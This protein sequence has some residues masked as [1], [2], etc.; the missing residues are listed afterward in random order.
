M[1]PGRGG[2]GGQELA[3]GH[4]RWPSCARGPHSQPAAEQTEAQRGTRAASRGAGPVRLNPTLLRAQS[5]ARWEQLDSLVA[6]GGALWQTP[7][8]PAAAVPSPTP[9][10]SRE[11]SR[12]QAQAQVEAGLGLLQHSSKTQSLGSAGQPLSGPLLSPHA[13]WGQARASAASLPGRPGAPRVTRGPACSQL[14]CCP[15]VWGGQASGSRAWPALVSG[16]PG[17]GQGLAVRLETPRPS[18]FL[19]PGL[20]GP[21]LGCGPG[22]C[23]L[24]S[25]LPCTPAPQ[26]SSHKEGVRRGPPEPPARPWCRGRWRPPQRQP[27]GRWAGRRPPGFGGPRAPA[28][29][30][31]GPWPEAG[32]GW[33][34][35]QPQADLRSAP[36]RAAGASS[37]WASGLDP[38]GWP[39]RP[40]HRLV[41]LQGWELTLYGRVLAL[42][43]GQP[44][45][46]R[47]PG[48]DRILLSSHPSRPRTPQGPGHHGPN[49][50]TGARLSLSHLS[51][52][53]VP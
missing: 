1:K 43:L 35:R 6:Q 8:T 7:G 24:L 22:S 32:Q 49:D 29:Q 14:S 10:G 21:H 44:R 34:P 36:P 9:P 18:S 4:R 11:A 23:P 31:Q 13:P 38:V 37:P 41:T 27:L 2:A 19:G 48:D 20:A 25:L 17:A 15:V 30:R 52:L 51:G 39:G 3:W 12:A 47:D 16:P 26:G 42:F 5:G 53:A 28:A 46:A 50:H 45:P 33:A 40:R